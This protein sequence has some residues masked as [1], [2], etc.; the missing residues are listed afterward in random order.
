MITYNIN[1]TKQGITENSYKQNWLGKHVKVILHVEAALALDIMHQKQCTT[2]RPGSMH[3]QMQILLGASI[4]VWVNYCKPK[5]QAPNKKCN[6][7]TFLAASI[8]MQTKLN[9]M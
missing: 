4:K 9:R 7:A 6:T 5:G 3:N 1:G 8:K 2:I